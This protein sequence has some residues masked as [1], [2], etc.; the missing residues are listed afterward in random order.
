MSTVLEV[1]EPGGMDLIPAQDPFNALVDAG[2][3]GPNLVIQAG[4]I[5]GLQTSSLKLFPYLS[6]N[7]DGTQNPVAIAGKSFVTDAA[8]AN[9]NSRVYF[10]LGSGS[11]GSGL[12]AAATPT[13]RTP[14]FSTAPIYKAGTFW[15]SQLI[16][17]DSNAMTKMLA[18][19][20][21][22][23]AVLITG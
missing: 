12:A 5:L 10:V 20:L 6:T 1:F 11:S 3:F 22:N 21:P 19:N 17:F 7:S 16:G 15:P 23:G 14:P 13:Y 4:T 18:K 8:D 9:G 2:A